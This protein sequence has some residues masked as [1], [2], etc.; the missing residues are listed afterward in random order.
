MA[1]RTV[2]DTASVRSNGRLL[3]RL[4][5]VL[6]AVGV[7]VILYAGVI[8]AWGDPVTWLWAH[9]QQRA[10]TSE[11]H[12][13]QQQFEQQYH[14]GTPPPDNSA[15]LADVR[16]EAIAFKHELKEGHAFG[17]LT[18]HRIGLSDVVVV[19]GT[20]AGIDADLS[21][22]PGHY[23]NTPFP[24]MGSSVAIAGHRTT[25][26]AW[27]RHI[28]EIRNGDH[29][30]LQM[31]YATFTYIVQK[32]QVVPNTDW[33]IIK[34]QGY[35]RLVLSACHPLYSASHR[36]VVFAKAATVTLPG[37]NEKPIPIPG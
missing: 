17:R 21:K 22:G 37:T 28:D 32:H 2:T 11:F 10:L 27:F 15:A 16:R 13:T 19:Q 3:R 25:Y 30:Q 29:I 24:G 8:L 4:S 36:W 6:I 12:K 9:W 31:P 26:G 1:T 34:P 20:T 5:T 18:I 14:L 7:G 33:G 35:E 23:M